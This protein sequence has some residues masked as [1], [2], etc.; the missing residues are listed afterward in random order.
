MKRIIAAQRDKRETEREIEN[1]KLAYQAALEG[2]VLLSNDGTLPI[3]PCRVALYGAG[4]KYTI[5]GG[6]GSGEVN[7]RHSVSI[8]EGLRNKGFSILTDAC[9]KKYDK[10]LFD[11]RA[12]YEKE[13]R[14]K[15]TIADIWGLVFSTPLADAV[16]KED[17]VDCETAIFVL[18]RQAGEG[19]DRRME[20]VY[21][22]DER[23]VESIK[24]LSEHYRKLILIINSG[25]SVDLSAL[26][27]YPINAI[28]FFCQQGMEGGNALASLLTGEENF[29][30]RLTDTWVKSYEDVPFGNEYSYLNGD[31][32]REYYREGIYVGYRYYDTFRVSVRY[33]F[34]YGLSY[35]TFEIDTVETKL[36]GREV[37]VKAAVENTGKV[38]GKQVVQVYVS[39][40]LGKLDKEY[41][42][43][44][45]FGKTRELL[46]GEKEVLELAFDM[47]YCSS[48]DQEENTTIL[49]KGNYIVMVGDCCSH[50]EAVAVIENQDTVI[51]F[52]HEELMPCR[53]SFEELKAPPRE[54]EIIENVPILKLDASAFSMVRYVYPKMEACSD[55][56]VAS[57]MK[58]LTLEEKTALVMGETLDDGTLSTNYI[59]TPGSV[60]RTS[61]RCIDKG[62]VNINLA[63][64]PAGL[65]LLQESGLGKD[66]RIMYQ[67]GNFPI[68]SM[69][70]FK[71]AEPIEEGDVLLYQYTT[72]FPV[73]TALAQSF[74]TSLIEEIGKRVSEEMC[75]FN[76]TYWLAPGMNIHRNP[77]C[78]RNFEYYSED[79]LLTGKIAAALIKGVQSISGN[80]I[81]IKHLACNSA[82]ENRT[83]SDSIVKGR[84]LREIYLKGF[85]IA[86]KE[87]CAS[88]AMTSYNKINGVYASDSYDMCVKIMRN[89][90][91]FDGVIMTDW[92][93]TL[94]GHADNI[95]AVKSGHL[96][97]P[98]GRYYYNEIVKGLKE[99]S[100]KEEELD[101]PVSFLIKAILDSNVASR[102]RAEDIV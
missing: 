78:G 56:R 12:A 39:C 27:G 25:S 97:M 21:R 61:E 69:E 24:L 19:K 23:E 99:G 48:F 91:G 79:P 75:R 11:A 65:R 93:A 17:L 33:P 84:A 40:P 70:L 1:R 22:P 82:E 86:V 50:T 66:G 37:K 68:A 3:K 4:A 43:L 63:D 88:G 47:G 52:K 9:L 26:E 100:L 44:V 46:P 74:N 89:E 77:L 18:A 73:A 36:I 32:N 41:K 34:G 30:A 38:K 59:Y 6:S 49:E 76:V 7:E 101:I 35:T 87:A 80:Y 15:Y 95:K 42:R 71:E 20:G 53:E 16:A 81:T 67:K 54:E 51:L 72:A 92:T 45:A 85:E 2:I 102:I 55:E 96:I 94:E 58:K 10:V 31:L 62:L 29:S 5:K 90:W 83:F 60:A 28:V 98:G 64:G 14:E 57:I 13:V 8:Y